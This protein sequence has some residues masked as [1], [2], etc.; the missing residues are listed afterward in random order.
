MVQALQGRVRFGAFQLDPKAGELYG[1]GET[2]ILQDQQLKV[3]LMLIERE[4]ELA[5]REEIRNRLWPNGTVVD[6]DHSINNAVKN[7]RR[8]LCD[9]AQQ[10]QYIET[11]AS[12][13]YRLKVPVEWI[14]QNGSADEPL[15]R[16]EGGTPDSVATTVPIARLSIGSLTGKVVSHYR[17]LELIGG[18]GMGLVYRAEDLKLGRAVALKFLPDEVGDDPQACE[19]FQRE[20]KAVSALDHANICSVYEFDEHEGHPFIVMQLLQG[21]TLRDHIAEGRFRL[22][23]PE[24]LEIAIQIAAGLEAAHEKGILHRDIKPANIFITEKNVAKIVDFGIAKMLE[25]HGSESHSTNVGLSGAPEPLQSANTEPHGVPIPSGASVDAADIAGLAELPISPAIESRSDDSAAGLGWSAAAP[26]KAANTLTR[27]GMTLGTAA[28]M[29]PEQVR[30][31]RLDAR[32]DIFSLG[33]VLYEMATG[34]RA[35]PG[36]TAVLVRKAILDSQPVAMPQSGPAV[37]PELQTVIQ[38]AMD[39]DRAQRYQSAAELR[40]ALEGLRPATPV[41]V[42]PRWTD[43]IL[44]A[45]VAAIFVLVVGALIWW[46]RR[47]MSSYAFQKFSMAPL[48]ETGNVWLADIS[49]D[50]RYLAYIDD[51]SGKQSLWLQQLSS[52]STVRLFG[53]VSNL[54]PGIR[55]TPDGS[56]IYFSRDDPEGG[57][58]NLYRIPVLGGAPEKQPPEAFHD[59]FYQ[60]DFSPDG[61]QI[62]FARRTRNGNSLVIANLDGSNARTLLTLP[63]TQPLAMPAWSPSG[64]QIAFLLDEK[65]SGAFNALSVVSVNDG[66]ERRVL[67]NVFSMFGVDWLG[68]ESGLVVTAPPQRKQPGIWIVSYPRGTLRRM[69]TD[70]TDYF[71]VSATKSGMSIATVQK[72]LDSSLWIAPAGDPSQVTQLR[73][74]AGKRDGMMGVAWL[75]DGNLVYVSEQGE[76]RNSL[77]TIS[78]DGRDRRRL[79]T[80][81]ADMHPAAPSAGGKIVFARV[82]S[83]SGV[84]DIWESSLDGSTAKRLTSGSSAKLGPDISPDGTWITYATFE[85]P[86]KMSLASGQI[87]NIGPPS[88]EY[89]TIS[90]DGKWIAFVATD[91]QTS[92]DVIQIVAYDQKTPSRLLPFIQEPQVPVSANLGSSPIRWTA[93]GKAITYVRTKNGVSNIWIQPIDGSPA[94]QLTSFTSMYIWRHAWSPDGK[95]LVLARG[96][97]SRDAVMLTDER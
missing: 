84:H 62:V 8:L 63:A 21:R 2:I 85:G 32:S 91:E 55:F 48:T 30:G 34:V 16:P 60:V 49:P 77:W 89:P 29:S 36:E 96:N 46:W 79:S 13:G 71:G 50:G 1:N 93:D 75:P 25:V 28:Y 69:T 68:D 33:L 47:P 67:Q 83:V 66:K 56:Y 40:A 20:A 81:D 9:N 10:P 82:D 35:F 86:M 14:P 19:R 88:G 26:A 45:V 5:T 15:P 57:G 6:W 87:T 31:E 95:Y 39:K 73:E 44:L 97:F 4:G 61:K 74:G 59:V 23:R 52:S 80:G 76:E 7:L 42:P 3:L 11:L 37:A 78:R 72:R 90:P 24:G 64:K 58:R 92:Q 41:E 27:T 18:G 54:R 70:L 12:R 51:E 17:V 94:R 53:P 43:K 65:S 22:S 38:K